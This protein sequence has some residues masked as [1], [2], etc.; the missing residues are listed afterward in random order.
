VTVRQL[1]VVVALIQ[2]VVL[3]ALMLLILLNRW[4]RPRTG[5]LHRVPLLHIR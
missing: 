1:L 5:R 3:V 2:G 4:V